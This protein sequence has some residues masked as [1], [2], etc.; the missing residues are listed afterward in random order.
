MDLFKSNKT[1]PTAGPPTDE[2]NLRAKKQKYAGALEAAG[3]TRCACRTCIG[4]TARS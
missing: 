3:K 2:Q 4:R 1:P